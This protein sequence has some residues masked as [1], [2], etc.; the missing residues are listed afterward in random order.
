M[1]VALPP[2]LGRVQRQKLFA[3]FLR[4][5]GPVCCI[6]GCLS[7]TLS[8][9][10]AVYVANFKRLACVQKNDRVPVKVMRKARLVY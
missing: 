2:S 6:P 9:Y 4:L 1:K 8:V 5:Y 7:S 10:L 3:A